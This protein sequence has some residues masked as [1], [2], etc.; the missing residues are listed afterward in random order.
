MQICQ[1]CAQALLSVYKKLCLA[2]LVSC[3]IP[4]NLHAS[5]H[6][7]QFDPV[8]LFWWQ[9]QNNVQFLVYLCDK[10]THAHL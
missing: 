5:C 9:S 8:V 7:Y 4:V 6:H 3:F 2:K 1:G 10:P